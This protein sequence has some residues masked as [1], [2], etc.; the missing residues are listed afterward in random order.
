[1]VGRLDEKGVERTRGLDRR[2][3]RLGQLLGGEGLGAQPV[4]HRG[5]REFGQ[6]GHYSITFGTAKKPNSACGAFA[7]TLSWTLPSVTSSARQ[8]SVF[9]ITAVIGSTPSVSTSPSCSIQLR[10]PFSS[11]SSGATS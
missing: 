5:E 7:R 9:G 2:D 3:M 1:M 8:R 10:M 11:R 6:L 4:A